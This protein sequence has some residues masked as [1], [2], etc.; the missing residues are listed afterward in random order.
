MSK[1]E[2]LQIRGNRKEDA[3]FWMRPV[4]SRTYFIFWI[5]INLPLTNQH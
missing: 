1:R 3:S 5:I 2:W 4:P